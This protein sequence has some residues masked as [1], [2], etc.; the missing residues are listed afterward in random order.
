[1][2]SEPTVETES[3][4]TASSP[5]SVPSEVSGLAPNHIPEGVHLPPE[6]IWPITLAFGI[7]VSF[8]GLMTTT[9]VSFIGLLIMFVAIVSWVQELRHEL[10]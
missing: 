10:H 6:S 3:G 5:I 2:T 8:L 1:M 9:L 7:T 4:L